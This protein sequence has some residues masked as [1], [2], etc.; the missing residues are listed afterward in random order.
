[1]GL[2][3]IN[4]MEKLRMVIKTEK[5]SYAPNPKSIYLTTAKTRLGLGE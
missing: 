3:T 2:N 5:Q 4:L 1:M